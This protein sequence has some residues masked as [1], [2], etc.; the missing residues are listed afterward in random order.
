MQTPSRWSRWKHLAVV[1]LLLS[2]GR[3]AAQ[4]AD[5]SFKTIPQQ[6]ETTAATK[7]ND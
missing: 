6:A 7:A 2:G 1:I 4:T 5:Q 3:V